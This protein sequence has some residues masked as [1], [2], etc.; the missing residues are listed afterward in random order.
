MAVNWSG[1]GPELLVQLQRDGSVSL[2]AQLERELREAIRSGRLTA[3]ERLP[4]SRAL[5]RELGISR[6]LVQECY[7]QLLA[8]GFLSTRRVGDAR[9]LDGADAA[10]RTARAARPGAAT[11]NQLRARTPRPG[12]LPTPGLDLGDAR[13]GAHRSSRRTGL[14]GSARQR[15]AA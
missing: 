7:A 1:L 12:Q 13:G 4:S 5:A 15:R 11:G 10:A 2:T 14:R 6:G 9:R 8:E 3:G